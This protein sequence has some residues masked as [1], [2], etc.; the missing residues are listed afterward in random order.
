MTDNLSEQLSNLIDNGGI[1]INGKTDVDYYKEALDV[2]E[3]QRKWINVLDAEIADYVARILKLEAA[4]KPFADKA[5][6]FPH[7][8]PFLEVNIGLGDLRAA[9]KGEK[10]N[11]TASD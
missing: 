6:M 10:N 5:D 2:I 1:I 7:F 11:D 8:H 4:L 9:Y 3:G